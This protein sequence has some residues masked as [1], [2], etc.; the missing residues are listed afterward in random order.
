MDEKENLRRKKFIQKLDE[1]GFN[2]LISKIQYNEEF[3]IEN[4]S[5]IRFNDVEH[6]L[7]GNQ[8]SFY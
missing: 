7:F 8:N 3:N 2:E 6:I 1:F 5:F 4:L